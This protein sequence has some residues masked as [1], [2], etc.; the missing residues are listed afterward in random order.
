MLAVDEPDVEV[1]DMVTQ[2]TRTRRVFG[3]SMTLA[4]LGFPL[5]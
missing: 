2:P 4:A 5:N 3:T 1:F